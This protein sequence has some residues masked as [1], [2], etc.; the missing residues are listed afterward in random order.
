MEGLDPDMT[1]QPCDSCIDTIM[2]SQSILV[3]FI[4]HQPNQNFFIAECSLVFKGGYAAMW[5]DDMNLNV[6][7]YKC[8]ISSKQYNFNFSHTI[9]N[10][11]WTILILVIIS[12]HHEWHFFYTA[13]PLQLLLLINHHML[14]DR[15]MCKGT[16]E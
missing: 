2:Q 16:T 6:W 8:M 4:H 13:D 5:F 15:N 11:R 3:V 1:H 9:F 14:H 10:F 7:M 12:I